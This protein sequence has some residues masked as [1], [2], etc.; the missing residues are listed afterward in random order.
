MSNLIYIM[1]KSSAGKDT[2]YQKVKERIDTNLYIPYTTR[3]MREGEN[4]G[5]EYNFITREE[6]N[7]LEKEQKVMENRNY[8]VI[9]KNGERDVWTYATIADEQW[10]QEGDFLSIGTLESYTSILKY[11][12]SHPEKDLTMMPVY[13]Q[14]SEEERKKRAIAREKTQIKP[15]FEEMERRLKAD[16]IDFSAEKLRDAGISQFETFENYN[17]KKC[18]SEIIEYIEKRREAVKKWKI[19]KD[20]ISR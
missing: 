11:L 3:P 20:K 15:N 2:I 14:I 18:V 12:R 4:Q 1:G 9:N 7:I 17:L 8:N 13:I 10:E 6:F 5:R 16:N 19:K